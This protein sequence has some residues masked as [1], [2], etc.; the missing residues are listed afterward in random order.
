VIQARPTQ[1]PWRVVG[2]LAAALD[3]HI[4]GLASTQNKLKKNI[5]E[6]KNE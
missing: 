2:I 5:S 3:L 4:G 1:L 6:L